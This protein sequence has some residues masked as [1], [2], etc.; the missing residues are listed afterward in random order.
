MTWRRNS[1]RRPHV[2]VDDQVWN[3]PM[4]VFEFEKF[5]TGT[6]AVAECLARL[7]ESGAIT[8]IGGGDS[9]SWLTEGWT[10]G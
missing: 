4:G 8:I 9:V 5:A 2:W 7:T 3:G 6:V 1:L 10:H